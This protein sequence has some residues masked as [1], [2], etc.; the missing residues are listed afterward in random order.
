MHTQSVQET[1]MF[2]HLDVA[3]RNTVTRCA[4]GLTLA[5]LLA[6]AATG[7]GAA[8][9]ILAPTAHAAPASLLSVNPTTA[10]R[11]PTPQPGGGNCSWSLRGAKTEWGPPQGSSGVH[12]AN[13]LAMTI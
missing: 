4:T 11:L 2:A 9:G 12:Y 3:L 10:A 13:D 8:V 1:L 5:L 7:M 6:L